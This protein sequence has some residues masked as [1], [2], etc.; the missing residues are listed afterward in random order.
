MLFSLFLCLTNK[1]HEEYN[2]SDS[3]RLEV[4]TASAR[5]GF[6]P[7]RAVIPVVFEYYERAYPKEIEEELQG[8]LATAIASGSLMAKHYLRDHSEVLSDAVQRFQEKG[9]YAEQLCRSYSLLSPLHYV[10]SFGTMPE[11]RRLV[12]SSPTLCLDERTP[13]GETA[14]YLAVARGAWDMAF[15]L[16]ERG[17]DA[18]VVCTDFRI[19]CLHWIFTCDLE[20]QP[21]AVS[22][23][24]RRGADINIL[25][26]Q[27][28]PFMHW[29]FLLPAGTPLHWAVALKAETAIRSL[30]Q[31]GAD[32]DIRD[33]SD[34]YRYD[35]DVRILNN[36]G[37]ITQEAF[38][39]PQ[40][41][42]RGLS[43]LDYAAM[44]HDPFIFETLLELERSVNV[45]SAEE[46][47]MTVLHHLSYSTSRRARSGFKYSDLPFRGS[48][49]SNS[50]GL[51]RTAL[52]IKS[53]GGDLNKLTT[54]QLRVK[55]RNEV[56]IPV[57]DFTPLM[58]AVRRGCVSVVRCLVKAGADLD[59]ENTE[60]ST[61]IRYLAHPSEKD[62]TL[63]IAQILVSAGADIH[64]K[65]HNGNTALLAAARSR[66]LEVMKLLL[67]MGADPT[68]RD[69]EPGENQD[70]RTIWVIAALYVDEPTER[71]FSSLLEQYVL[72]HDPHVVADVVDR[73][74]LR[75][76]KLLH[77]LASRLML[78]SVKAM[79]SHGVD[80][81]A[82]SRRDKMSTESVN[83]L[84]VNVRVEWQESPLD[85]VLVEKA[86]VIDDMKSMRKYRMDQFDD[87]CRRADLIAQA[88]RDAGGVKA[89]RNETRT[90][91]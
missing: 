91:C 59:A 63:Q 26:P 4:L 13:E 44:N 15:F 51:R 78:S 69:G 72:L 52:A 90:R 45:N 40:T 50:D 62:G 36:F 21:R 48:K 25:I 76:V 37:G 27:R 1:F 75:G 30:L 46:E 14:L 24:T 8:W 3:L 39:V 2:I 85:A 49:E 10:A 16:L 58:L 82:C 54:P 34:P 20:A 61:A 64:H 43:A 77:A 41:P 65:G 73:P 86:R 38:S 32:P 89:S 33:K 19:S 12:D 84:L 83:G 29:P 42:T 81:N 60:K 79:I 68:E 23:L 74:D 17:A 87:L 11:L 70:N 18:T 67:S 56:I 57:P 5:R 31:H 35:H 66:Q 22:E 53:L 47:G 6:D 80:V 88:I 28:V 71:L 7:A 55:K 9:G